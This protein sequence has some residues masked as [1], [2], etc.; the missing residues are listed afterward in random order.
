MALSEKKDISKTAFIVIAVLIIVT[1]AVLTSLSAKLLGSG[2]ATGETSSAGGGTENGFSFIVS[3]DGY[4]LSGY[5]GNSVSAIVPDTFDGKPVV[6]VSD[7]AFRDNNVIK[8]VELP[9]T[10][11]SIGLEAFR[12]CASLT[13]ITIPDSV[14]VIGNNAFYG[15]TSLADAELPQGLITVGDYAFAG[16]VALPSITL[17]SRTAKIG[18]QAFADC[19]AVTSLVIPDSVTSLGNKAFYACTRLSDVSGGAGLTRVGGYAFERTVWLRTECEKGFAVLGEMLVKVTSD[20]LFSAP[21]GI[22][23]VADYAFYGL[24]GL[25]GVVFQDELEYIGTYAF[26]GCTSLTALTMPSKL[27]SIGDG[28]FSGCVSLVSISFP[29][30]LTSIG[31][32]CFFGCTALSSIAVSEGSSSFYADASAL[33]SADKTRLYRYFPAC[34]EKSFTVPDGVLT[35]DTDSFSGSGSLETVIMC[36]SVMELGERVFYSCRNLKNIVF[37][38]DVKSVPAECFAFCTSL[39]SIELT[40]GIASVAQ[41]AFLGCTSLVTVKLSSTVE[42]VASD[43]FCECVRLG[44]LTVDSDSEYLTVYDGVLFNKDMTTLILCPAA[45]EETKYE[46]PD[47]VTAINSNAFLYCGSIEYIYINAALTQ[48]GDSAFYGCTSLRAVRNNSGNTVFT[49]SEGVLFNADMTTL[50]LFPPAKPVTQYAVP[51]SVTKIGDS[52]F[53]DVKTLTSLSIG[54]NVTAFGEEVFENS[55][56]TVK[57]PQGSAAY[58]YCADNGIKTSVSE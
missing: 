20:G 45:T 9:D 17:G 31:S 3:S 41:R 51:D 42:S 25:N 13:R 23:Y 57:C 47:T 48:I 50:L 6:A 18:E 56:L 53:I 35:L 36:S 49:C 52:A 38:Q 12:M 32:N 22:A 16:C 27:K 54:S 30:S 43:A 1:A 40:E 11:T 44:G 2:T 33:Y 39:S 10:V 55:S 5:T 21:E 19:S 14:T 8:L 46:L 15:C 4:A 7:G 26:G 37:S 24:T 34:T 28:V 58:D 29:A